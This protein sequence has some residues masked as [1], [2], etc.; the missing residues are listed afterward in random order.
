MDHLL[1]MNQ[2][3]GWMF[4]FHLPHL[5]IILNQSHPQES[6]SAASDV[7]AASTSSDNHTEPKSPQ[8]STSAAS[9]VAAASTSSDNHTQPKSPQESAHAASDVS[10]ASTSSDNHTQ[11]KSPK[12]L[13]LLSLMLLLHLLHL[14]TI[15][16]QSHPKNCICCL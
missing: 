13:H 8:E 6:A 11:P 12:N 7:S 5:T 4:L 3:Q 10:A 16:N 1:L 9:D 2:I 15:L 14:T